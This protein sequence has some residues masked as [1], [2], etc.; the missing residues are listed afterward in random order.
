[1]NLSDLVLSVCSRFSENVALSDLHGSMT[2]RQLESETRIAADELSSVLP[3]D[4]S[5]VMVSVDNRPTDFVWELAAWSLGKTVIPVHVSMPA[6]VV[7]ATQRR[8]GASVIVGPSLPSAW[9]GI[10][11]N[12]ASSRIW[13]FGSAAAASSELGAEIALVI[14][15]SGST[16]QPKG[17][18]IP[19][20]K[21]AAKVKVNTERLDFNQDTSLFH[22]LHL[23]FSFG[24]WTSLATL[25]TG[26]LVECEAH[27]NPSASLMRLAER[28]YDFVAVVPTMMRLMLPLLGDAQQPSAMTE[29]LRAVGSPGQWIAG[30]EPL[31][32]DLG[33]MFRELLPHAKISDVYGLSESLT[34]DFMLLPE[35]YDS[36]PGT[37]GWPSQGVSASIRNEV[38]GDEVPV[39][40]IGELCLKTEFLM[41]GY[42]GDLDATAATQR[43]GWFR[44]GDLSRQGSA[45]G[46]FELVGRSKNLIMRG[47]RKTS[48]LE[49]EAAAESHPHCEASIAVPVAEEQMGAEIHLLVSRSDTLD[50]SE[51]LTWIADRLERYKVPSRVHFVEQIPRGTTG[52]LDRLSAGEIVQESLAE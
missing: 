30:G 22:A 25:S 40:E 35:L 27:F 11:A 19:H 4:S 23:N 2:Y 7:R 6:S 52:K 43:D 50:E 33:T 21:F 51:L 26:G 38:T 9:A 36:H 14:F 3:L 18:K 47:G 17:V 1:M 29:Q 8:T 42:L 39:G 10:V 16:G 44:T 12:P 48:P 24:Q 41:S 20:G 31:S 32:A 15:T 13:Q 34:S 5:A 46:P 45:A 49:I 37:I 28:R